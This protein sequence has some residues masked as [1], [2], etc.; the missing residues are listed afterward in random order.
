MGCV[1]SVGIA[2]DGWLLTSSLRCLVG[3]GGANGCCCC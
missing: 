1:D 2:C 3:S